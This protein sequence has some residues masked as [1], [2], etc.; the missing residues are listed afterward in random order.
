MYSVDF[1]RA[2][3][4]ID[5]TLI[6]QSRDKQYAWHDSINYTKSVCVSRCRKRSL[7]RKH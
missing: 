2:R 3:C 6:N 7:Y 1:K 4:F 5:G